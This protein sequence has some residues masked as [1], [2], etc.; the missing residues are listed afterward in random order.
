MAH[1]SI[2]AKPKIVSLGPLKGTIYE[3]LPY[4]VLG[5]PTPVLE[6]FRDGKIF[7]PT[8]ND[9]IEQYVPKVTDNT[10]SGCLFF[11]IKTHIYNGNYTLV[12]ENM[13]GQVNRTYSVMLVE[14]IPKQGGQ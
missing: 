5:T 6:W 3:C 13:Y 12:A 9:V 8:K 10:I 11:P 14:G 1:F 4:D 7:K 2:S